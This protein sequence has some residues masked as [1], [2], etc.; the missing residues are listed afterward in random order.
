MAAR[1]SS[2]NAGRIRRWAT[3]AGVTEA[4][5]LAHVVQQGCIRVAT[6]NNQLLIN[7]DLFAGG[8]D[9]STAT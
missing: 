6:D 1:V 9:G 5:M 7:D 4:D 8:G 2:D 3:A